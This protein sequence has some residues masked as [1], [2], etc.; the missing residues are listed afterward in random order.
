M[1]SASRSTLLLHRRKFIRPPVLAMLTLIKV[2]LRE[3][4]AWGRDESLDEASD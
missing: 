4:P 2:T 3:P 1:D